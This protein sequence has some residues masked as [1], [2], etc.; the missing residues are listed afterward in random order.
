LKRGVWVKGRVTDKATGQPVQALVEYFAFAGNPDLRGIKVF[1]GSQV[2][3]SKKDGSFTLAALRGRGIVAVKTDEMRRGTYLHGQGADAIS[4]PRDE[5]LDRFVT[6]PYMC[7]SWQFDTLVGIETDAKAESVACD[8]QLDPGKT[9]KGTVLDPDGE[10][11]AGASI[12]GPFLSL[13]SLRDLPSAEFAIPAVNPN[14]PEA[15]F[16]EHRKRNLAAAVILKGDGAAGF[17]VKLKPTATLTGRLVTE[18][19]EPV[20]DRFISGRLE[21]GQL[22]MTRSW[23]G[24]FFGRTGADGRFKIEGLLAGVKLGDYG[25][26]FTNLTLQPGEVRDLGDIQVKN[27]PD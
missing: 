11:L 15:Y 22:K 12:R 2:V 26:L 27:V 24:F 9:V 19:G 25:N 18:K 1:A 14:K 21:A 3:S 5:R 16:F 23:N 10:P 17:T 13:K 4:G 8:V 7:V 20:R 6:R